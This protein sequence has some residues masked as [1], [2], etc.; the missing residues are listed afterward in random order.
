MN[1]DDMTVGTEIPLTQRKAQEP[2]GKH[3]LSRLTELAVGYGMAPEEFI[4]MVL[5]DFEDYPKRWERCRD[6]CI[7]AG[8]YS[9]GLQDEALLLG[10]E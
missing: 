2:E 9:G 4:D 5:D 3:G 8:L 10:G 1:L 6:S 7:H